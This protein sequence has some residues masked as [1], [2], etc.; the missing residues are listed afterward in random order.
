MDKTDITII[1]AGVVGL[2]VAAR[3]SEKKKQTVLVEKNETFGRETSSRNSEVIHS[4]I[5]YPK[6][7]LKAKLCLRGSSMLYELCER[8]GIG[9]SRTGKLI[10]AASPGEIESLERLFK[11]GRENGVEGLELLSGKDLARLEPSVSGKA[12]IHS[13]D[14]GI[15]DSHSLMKY[16]EFKARENNCLV[17]YNSE[18]TG[19]EKTNNAVFSFQSGVLINCAGLN[20]H[21]V[22]ELA[23]IKKYEVVYLKGEYFSLS[24]PPGK[25]PSRLIYPLPTET[26]LGIHTVK[27][28]A[29]R[30]RIG[31][32]SFY[33]AR[34]DYSVDA[35]HKEEFYGSITKLLPFIGE[36]DL[37][38]DM[39]GIRPE[40]KKEAGATADFVIADERNAG[41]SGFIN[42]IGISSPGLTAATAIADYVYSVLS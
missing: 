29:G 34:L 16:L 42:L 6:N 2:A 36:E 10:V 24:A 33:T 23:G 9:F 37:E 35:N 4:G 20:A 40:I 26:G 12:A 39:A 11:N 8:N 27:D 7:S 38:P 25:M 15:I 13:P 5:Y 31:P 18:L 19:I 28:L 3:V 21:A 1:G 32:N 17:S 14:T 22:A 41:F 30:V